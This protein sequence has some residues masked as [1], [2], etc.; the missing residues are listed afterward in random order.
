M[1]SEREQGAETNKI[2]KAVA[3]KYE[4]GDRSAPV[5]VAKGKGHVADLILGRAREN[6]IPVQEDPSLVEVLSKLDIDQEIPP[7]LYTLV[8]EILSFVYRSDRRARELDYD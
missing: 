4:P 1:S 7:E 8:A 5:L 2:N 3:I 6:G